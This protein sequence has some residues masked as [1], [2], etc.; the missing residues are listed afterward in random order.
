[1]DDLDQRGDDGGDDEK[2][3]DSGYICKKDEVAFYELQKA[4][5]EQDFGF[6]EVEDR[7]QK[8]S[9]GHIKFKVAIRLPS[10]GGPRRGTRAR[11]SL[12][13]GNLRS[14]PSARASAQRP[15]KPRSPPPL[16]APS[17]GQ[18]APPG[19]KGAP[20]QN[21]PR[22]FV[23]FFS[24]NLGPAGPLKPE[25]REAQEFGLAGGK[26]LVFRLDSCFLQMRG[27]RAMTAKRRRCWKHPTGLDASPK[28][29]EAG[30]APS[31]GTR[32]TSSCTSLCD[33]VPVA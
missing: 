31:Y 32:N 2:W 9:M 4:V 16:L 8:S 6:Y 20:S 23:C 19:E 27:L 21:L 3:S 29:A 17:L 1:M 22:P 14:E 11:P 5:R 26:L 30:T 24:S 10:R 12:T 28:A 15:P 25:R 13:P 7:N 33:P 18:F